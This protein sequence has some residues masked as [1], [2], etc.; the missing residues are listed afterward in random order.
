MEHYVPGN[1]SKFA[2]IASFLGEKADHGTLLDQAHQAAR[3][4]KAI[5]RDLKIPQSL[6]EL[7]I[8]EEA[9][10]MMARS[11]VTMTRMIEGN[12]RNI[13]VEDAIK[14]YKKAL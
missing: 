6:T 9:I 1:I 13:T 2:Q 8:S 14:I 12:P 7:K 5:Y 11:A 4:V 10:P 3:A